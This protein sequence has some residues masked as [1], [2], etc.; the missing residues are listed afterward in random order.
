MFT[1]DL[2]NGIQLSDPDF[3]NV[4]NSAVVYLVQNA[5]YRHDALVEVKLCA[6]G[7]VIAYLQ[8]CTITFGGV[9]LG[10]VTLFKRGHLPC[11]VR[12]FRAVC[13]KSV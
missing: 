4:Y 9:T 1:A 2:G 7:H 5:E 12:R 6:Y 3:R 11:T 13:A 10:R 8:G